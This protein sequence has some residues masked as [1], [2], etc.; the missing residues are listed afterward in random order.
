MANITEHKFLQATK[1][2]IILGFVLACFALVMAWAV[3]KV[4]L[5]RILNTVENLSTPNDRLRIVNRLSHQIA[6]LD[7]VQKN[8]ALKNP[9]NYAGFYKETTKLKLSVDTLKR[10]YQKDTTQLNRLN[11]LKSLLNMRERQFIAYLKVREGLINNNA[12]T[13]E[14]EKLNE[15]VR[16]RFKG[17]DTTLLTTQT[18]TST[19][20]VAPEEEKS[21]G[22]LSKLFGKKKSEVYQIISEELQIK[23]DTIGGLSEDSIMR[24]MEA[25]LKKI[26]QEQQLKSKSFIKRE[27]VLAEAN[28]TLTQQMLAVLRKV[29]AEAVAQIGKN[30]QDARLLVN[31][32]IAE[33][34]Y[35]ILAFFLLTVILLYFI[36]TDIT[37]SNKYRKA[38]ELAK[39]ESE[40][41]GRAKQR[42]LANM[43]HEIRTPLQSILGYAQLVAQQTQPNKKDISAI[44]Q[45]AV[46]LLQ[47]VNEV[48]DY[49]R[50]ISG[51]FTFNY[52]PFDIHQ[53]LKETIAA[54]DPLAEQKNLTLQADLALNGIAFVVGDAFR[55]KQILFNLI[56]NAIKFTTKGGVMLSVSY[57]Q[58]GENL[59][60]NFV[61][62][63]TGLGIAETDLESI[64]NEFEQVDSKANRMLNQSGT[65]LGLSIVKSLVE[66]QGGRIYAQSTV[67]KGSA[68]SFFLTYRMADKAQHL[69][70]QQ[71][72]PQPIATGLVWMIDDDQLILDLCGSIFNNANITYQLF[73]NGSAVLKA[74]P[75]ANIAFVL[76]DM[77]L[78]DMSGLKLYQLLKPKLSPAVKFYAV[79]A[80]VLPD[81][82]AA[83]INAGFD[84]II[85]KPFTEA[86]ILSVFDHELPKSE[87][88][89]FDLSVIEKMTFGDEQLLLSFLIR[90]KE[91]CLVDQHALQQ[92]L[93][94]NNRAEA[95]LITHRLAGRVAQIGAK[96][97]AKQLRAAELKIAEE[98]SINNAIKTAVE[99][100]LTQL[101]T[102]VNT[103]D[104]DYVMP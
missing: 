34:S 86:D 99:Q 4:A 60:F 71:Y 22:F 41:H 61:V 57:K 67:G 66:Q 88:I 52:E 101:T 19:T 77:R 2:K 84:G 103:I 93:A 55:L 3:N 18:T 83:V 7:Q 42:F 82:R 85:M 68:F 9:G 14:V 53:L 100:L 11:T 46:H 90:F 104:A 50:I 102:L 21:R 29:E 32:G 33:V 89:N 31:K 20:T 51:E 17:T 64:F 36:L 43:S 47:I 28:F 63:D 6:G 70:V 79:T 13:A 75:P 58:D 30:G 27:A 59:H 5:Q 15:M 44:Y 12:Y 62:E 23:R 98:S 96:T 72:L 25:S 40:Y 78:P 92:A 8:Q 73:N 81:E 97:L 91:D 69:P 80:Q 26:A 65:G 56:G 39:E 37:K 94:N 10:L 24:N 95:R 38:L 45:S 35:I 16:T 74:Q 54:M 48:L 49:N 87:E 1:G 76:I